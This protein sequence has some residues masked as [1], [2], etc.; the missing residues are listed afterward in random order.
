MQS[1]GPEQLLKQRFKTMRHSLTDGREI[2]SAA[3]EMNKEMYVRRLGRY[4]TVMSVAPVR[5]TDWLVDE[6]QDPWIRTS[7]PISE[8]VSAMRKLP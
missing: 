7:N 3:T 6:D 8:G 5:L 2:T 4:I 1:L